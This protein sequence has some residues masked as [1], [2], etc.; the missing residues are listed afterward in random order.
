MTSPPRVPLF[1][2]AAQNRPLQQEIEAALRAVVESQEFVLGT[3][4]TAFEAE[5]AE[6]CGTRF[7]VGCASGSDA[8]L[9]ALMAL[10][11]GPGDQVVCP[12]LTFFATASAIARLGATPVFADIDPRTYNLDPD[13]CAK[14]AAGCPRLR[15][16][17]PVHLFGRVAELDPLLAL[18]SEREI[19]LIE[20]AAQSVGATD[21][22]GKMSGS[23]GRLGAFSLYPTKNLGAMGDAGMIITDDEALFERLLRLR[24]HGARERYYHHEI[25]INSRL[26]ELQAAVLRIKLRHLDSWNAA[27][28]AN[29]KR[30]D[31]AFEAAGA[32]RS[33]HGESLAD[34]TLPLGTPEPAS[35][36]SGHVYHHYCVRVSSDRRDALRKHLAVHGIGSETYYPLG[37][38]QQ[39]CFRNLDPTHLPET[40]AATQQSLALPIHPGL[41]EAQIAHVTDTTIRY[42]A[43]GI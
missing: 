9:L 8:L 37:L 39:E 16:I 6:Y 33:G 36:T 10:E 35:H 24:G 26:D 27:R 1:D 14:V 38:H 31:E 43:R 28:Q 4:G 40:E 30:Y 11:I 42:L 34:A 25:G 12:S 21:A 15:A 29:A 17:L 3:Q 23:I 32:I 7:A 5:F 19:P 18:A 13:H 41:T 20:D 22:R 2:L